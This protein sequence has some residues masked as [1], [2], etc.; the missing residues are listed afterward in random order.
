MICLRFSPAGAGNSKRWRYGVSVRSVQ[1]CGCGEQTLA[2]PAPDVSAG[3][4]LRVRGTGERRTASRRMS[5][6][7]PAG[8]GNS[9]R[10]TPPQP[11]RTVQPCGCGEQTGCSGAFLATGR[12]S[13]AGAGN[14]PAEFGAELCQYGSALRVR[15]T[16]VQF[17]NGASDR[18]FSP[19]GAGNR[20]NFYVRRI[21]ISVQPCGCGEQLAPELEDLTHS[22]SALRVRGTVHKQWP[23]QRRRRFSPAGAGN[24]RPPIV[25]NIDRAVQPCGCGEQPSEGVR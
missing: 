2:R 24:R 6:F 1:P 9:E 5:R 21:Q 17:F 25:T 23:H 3:S 14:S 8:A 7:S 20:R 11:N 22:G 16:V 10:R 4:A 15:G 12:F 13:P 19:A 18:R